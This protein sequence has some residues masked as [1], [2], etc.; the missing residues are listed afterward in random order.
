MDDATV[1][2]RA[3]T[4][5]AFLDAIGHMLDTCDTIAPE[6]LKHL[7]RVTVPVAI[8]NRIEDEM[9]DVGPEA[10]DKYSSGIQTLD[11]GIK[12]MEVFGCAYLECSRLRDPGYKS[13]DYRDLMKGGVK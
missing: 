12:R 5:I 8:W 2:R 4:L 9:A 1:Q 13:F 7:L 6:T 3:P 11:G 10:W